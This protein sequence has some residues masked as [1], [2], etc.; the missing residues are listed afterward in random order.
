MAVIPAFNNDARPRWTADR[1]QWPLVLLSGHATP[2]MKKKTPSLQE[3]V[4]E[5]SRI[6]RQG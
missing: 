4:P 2:R 6:P 1:R 5:M 3:T